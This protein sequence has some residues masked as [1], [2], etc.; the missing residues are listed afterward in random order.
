[1]FVKRKYFFTLES[2]EVLQH[3]LGPPPVSVRRGQLPA[4]GHHLVRVLQRFLI[5]GLGDEVL[6]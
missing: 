3:G 2:V 6:T 5:P 1:M 4:L